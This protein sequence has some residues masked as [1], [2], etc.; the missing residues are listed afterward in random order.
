MKISG[1]HALTS[2]VAVI[3]L[4]VLPGGPAHPTPSTTYWSPCVIDIQPFRIVHFTYDNYTS[5]GRRGPARG[6]SA[7]ANDLGLTAGVLP[8]SGFQMEVGVDVLEPTDDPWSFNAKLGAPEGVL[9][10]GAPALQFGIFNVGTRRGVTDQNVVYAVTGRSLPLG[11]GRIHAG[12]YAGNGKV[13]VSSTG[14]RQATGVMVACDVTL[15]TGRDA[16]GEFGRVVLAGDYVS[17]RNWLGGGGV[18]VYYYFA[19]NVDV[20]A[21]P[22]W[23][24]DPGLN[25]DW[26]WTTQVDANF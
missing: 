8:F 21:G 20:L 2:L 19:R 25:G 5:F 4:P 23:F 7:F 9:F 14:L 12:G 11:F 15:R 3:V 18:G 1:K 13:L 24:N 16:A 22:V 6:G 26:K 17:G 10:G